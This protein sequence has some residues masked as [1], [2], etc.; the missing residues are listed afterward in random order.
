[1]ASQRFSDCTL[2]EGMSLDIS[3]LYRLQIGRRNAF[4]QYDYQIFWSRRNSS[5]SFIRSKGKF[6]SI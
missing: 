4:V 5:G 1:M 2:N 6:T 3:K